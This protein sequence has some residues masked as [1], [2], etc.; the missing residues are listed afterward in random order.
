MRGGA[1]LT[2]LG[3]EIQPRWSS[4]LE[5][6]RLRL[7][8]SHPLNDPRL[9]TTA[10]LEI[11]GDGRVLARA[12]TASANRDF[13][14]AV[15]DVLAEIDRVAP[16]PADLWSDDDRVHVSWLFARDA[17]QAGP[18]TASIVTV[19]Q[20]LSLVVSRRLSEG[21]VTRA[22]RR[23]LEASDLDPDVP[24]ATRAVMMAALDEALRGSRASRVAAIE[25]IAA[26]RLTSFAAE[27]RPLLAPT[28]DPE[29][30]RAAIEAIGVLGDQ[31]AIELVLGA[32]PEDL[33][34]A[35][36]IATVSTRALV[37]LGAESR[38]VPVLV[39]ALA[40][41]SATQTSAL[42]AMSELEAWSLVPRM[43]RAARSPDASVRAAACEALPTMRRPVLFVARGLTDRAAAV[44]AA[45]ADALGRIQF[46]G[47]TPGLRALLRDRDARVR[48]TALAMV[49][50]VDPAAVSAAVTDPAD[51]VRAAVASHA[52]LEQ[53]L[54]LAGDL[55]PSVRASAFERLAHT[56]SAGDGIPRAGRDSAPEVRAVA[57]R[58][59]TDPQLLEKLADDPDDAVATLALER[60]VATR[61]RAS[62]ARS[63]LD[64]IARAAPAT[65]ARVRAARAYL[66]ARD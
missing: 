39:A 65:A 16:P 28:T 33:R 23:A 14:R 49:G 27:L 10:H 41:D 47:K 40:A 66:A 26:A 43:A 9:S 50:D 31:T 30:R 51:E 17:R 6:C 64:R 60:L 24:D 12:V 57:A 21:D 53:L 2:T 7:S 38:V 20:P 11:A 37:A 44:R 32:L 25:T 63:L 61:G 22:A 15:T 5:D 8:T 13:D 58:W 34:V 62:M 46:G 54:V 35:P 42:R 45:C 18:A 56:W 1:Y 55:V 4:F 19:H 29:V 52:P 3:A 59:T 36:A 48:A